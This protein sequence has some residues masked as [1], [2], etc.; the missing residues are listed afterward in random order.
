MFKL[1]LNKK[2]FSFLGKTD[3]HCTLFLLQS[4]LQQYKSNTK[5]E[6]DNE[7]GQVRLGQV[8]VGEVNVFDSDP[9][10]AV[11]RKISITVVTA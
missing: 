3:L 1:T 10:I 8:K 5:W 6:Q 9:F 4:G 11:V 2:N 7:F